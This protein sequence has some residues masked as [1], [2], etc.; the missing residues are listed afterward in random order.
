MDVADLI[1]RL[2]HSHVFW[3]TIRREPQH[4]LFEG[5]KNDIPDDILCSEVSYFYP[6]PL[7]HT[8][9]IEIV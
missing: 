5:S 3:F 7:N 6:S 9:A 2:K 4:T 8:I 1:N